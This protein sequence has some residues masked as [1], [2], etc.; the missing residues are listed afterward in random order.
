MVDSLK[1][2]Q[3]H[4]SE[5]TKQRNPK[6]TDGQTDRQTHRRIVQNHFPRRFEGCISQ[7]WSYLGVEFLHD[8]NTSL[9]H[10]I[11]MEVKLRMQTC[12]YRSLKPIL[13]N[14]VN[15]GENTFSPS[16]NAVLNDTDSVAFVNGLYFLTALNRLCTLNECMFWK[17]I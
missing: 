2:I 9:G 16:K 12:V 1:I 17:E 4:W 3:N 15:R 6:Q 8:A 11:D 7:I 10:G 14:S 5:W 13:P